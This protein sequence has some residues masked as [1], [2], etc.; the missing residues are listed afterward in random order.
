MSV[1]KNK[2]LKFIKKQETSGNNFRDKFNQLNDYLLPACFEIFKFQKFKKK[3]V[4]VSLSGGQGAGK[5][6]LAKIFQ[7]ILSTIYKLKVVNISIDDFY[8]TS[9]ERKKMSK[10]THPLFMTRGVPGTH[11]SKM[12]YK[13]IKKLKD[14]KFKKLTIPK[15]DKSKDD[16]FK[17]NFWQ[18]ITKK[19][20]IVIFEGWCVGAKP[21]KKKDLIKSINLLEKR[22]DIKLTWRK[23]V[24]NELMINYKKIFKLIDYKIYIKVPSFKHVF[25][26]RLLQEKK[27][28]LKS[29][30]K[31]VMKTNE[32]KRFIMFY[33]RITKDMMKNFKDNNIIIYLS[34]NHKIKSINIH[35]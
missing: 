20:D 26:W 13:V 14:K 19:P 30:N 23:K 28:S 11:D 31:S 1:L 22:D 32:V 16:R 9:N 8:K 7:I 29:K 18:K 33:E 3:T 25:R 27:L 2:Y 12:L 6:T 4:V 10:F 24:N 34:N 5:S 15:F 17:Q 21:Q 35:D